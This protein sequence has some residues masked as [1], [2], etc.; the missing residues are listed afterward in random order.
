MFSCDKGN[1]PQL[2]LDQEQEYVKA[3]ELTDISEPLSLVLESLENEGRSLDNIWIYD[4]KQDPLEKVNQLIGDDLINAFL[5][6]DVQFADYSNARTRC[7]N[8]HLEESYRDGA[9]NLQW[10]ISAW[11]CPASGDGNAVSFWGIFYGGSG[12]TTPDSGSFSVDDG[13]DSRSD[14]ISI[15]EFGD[16]AIANAY[17]LKS[18]LSLTSDQYDWLS[19]SENLNLSSALLD[20]I[21]ENHSSK[22]SKEFIKQAVPAFMNGHQVDLIGMYIETHTPDDNYDYQGSKSKIPNQFVLS[23]GSRL[24]VTFETFTSDGISSNQPVAQHLIDG[25]KYALE[26]ANKNLSSSEKITSINIYATT[27]GKHGP[28]SNPTKGTA[29]ILTRLSIP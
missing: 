29:V 17:V 12:S 23:D 26:E 4:G 2:N 11:D 28:N 16:Q 19:D 18:M 27:N 8:G 25:I 15:Y 13:S 1:E 3:N 5:H 6:N 7:R 14:D 20:F 9:G 10:R 21:N 22:E 24:D